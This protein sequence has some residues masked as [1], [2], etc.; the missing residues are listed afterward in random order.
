MP[1]PPRRTPPVVRPLPPRPR[2]PVP[3]RPGAVAIPPAVQ[4]LG[5]AS[6]TALAAQRRDAEALLATIE[7]QKGNIGAGFYEIGRALAT[8]IDRKLHVALGYP[9]FAA[10]VEQRKIM[11]RAFAWQL[12]AIYRSIPRETVQQLGPQRAFEWLR[13]LR[14]QA[15]PDAGQQDVQHLAGQEAQVDGHPVAA[16]TVT[17]LAELRRKLQERRDAARRDPGAGEAHRTA[18]ALA[19]YL[20]HIGAEHARVGARFSRGVWQIHAVLD[21]PSAQVIYGRKR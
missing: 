16:M 5:A 20:Q 17:E 1:K 10:M 19:Q 11:S 21:V 14:V 12:I 13:L 7:R 2:P 6:G 8:L 15:G 18:R 3:S 4:N 9:S